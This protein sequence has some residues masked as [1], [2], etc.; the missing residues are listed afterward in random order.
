MIRRPP[1][2]T[3]FP[4]TT[5]FRPPPRAGPSVL[6]AV[7]RGAPGLL[8][9]QRRPA[10][11]GA[12]TAPDGATAAPLRPSR[13]DRVRRGGSLPERARRQAVPRAVPG[14]GAVPAAHRAALRAGRRARGGRP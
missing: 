4:Y 6:P 10:R 5:L 2:S 3:L 13:P 8:A 11:H 12:L 9:A 1:R 14:L 7:P